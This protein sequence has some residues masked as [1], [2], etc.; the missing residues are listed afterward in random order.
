MEKDNSYKLEKLR[1]TLKDMGSCLVAFSGGV[2]SSFLLKM[3]S[4][5][6]GKGKVLAVSAKAEIF[7]QEELESAKEMA[8][9]IGV[10]HVVIECG[11]LKIPQ[12]KMN[13]IDRCYYCKT[14]I[15]QKLK[16]VA[17]EKGF[18]FVLD[19]TNYDDARD[20]RPGMKALRELGTRSLLKEAMITKEDIRYFSRR[21][22]LKTW[23]KPSL[24]CL[25]S[26][27]PYGK[28][29]TKE[30]LTTVGEA[31][32]FLRGLGFKQV[33]VRHHGEI[34]RIELEKNDI[35]T[36]ISK[37]LMDKVVKKFKELGFLYVTLDLQGYR[38]GSM[39][40]PL[41]KAKK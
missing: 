41:K 22:G 6:L 20:Y 40:E 25:A 28:E 23:D 5:V 36:L 2:D 18:N 3:A 35:A 7:P 16:D 21:M 34:A 13:P 31:E 10:E 33:R 30:K 32:S 24:A 19:G 15:F 27:F 37:G 9:E 17:K 39:D 11:P 8:K 1:K 38:M 29:I 14:Q 26:R 4:E 12:F